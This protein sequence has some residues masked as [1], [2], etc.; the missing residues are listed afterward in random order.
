[1]KKG[2]VEGSKNPNKKLSS[3]FWFLLWGKFQK[4]MRTRRPRFL[5]GTRLAVSS[6]RP[7]I[8]VVASTA[9]PPLL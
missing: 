6:K 2:E 1:V 9:T 3:A 7:A 5:F 8:L 4:N